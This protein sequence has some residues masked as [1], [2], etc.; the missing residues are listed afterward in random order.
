MKIGLLNRDQ[1]GWNSFMAEWVAAS[2]RRKMMIL[3]RKLVLL[4]FLL[5]V[6]LAVRWIAG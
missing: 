1:A 6:V 5:A 3:S 2:P 4:L